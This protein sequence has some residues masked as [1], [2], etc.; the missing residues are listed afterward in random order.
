MSDIDPETF[1]LERLKQHGVDV[2]A[3][4]PFE[5][6][7]DRLGTAIIE[8]RFGMVIVG[9]SNGKPESYE[10]LFERIYGVK[11]KDVPRLAP[12]RQAVEAGGAR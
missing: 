8:N 4:G 9:R 1:L 2:Y 6:L 3:G 11:L 10:A 12:S 7:R 5:C